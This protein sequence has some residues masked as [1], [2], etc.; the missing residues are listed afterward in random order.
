VP[1]NQAR[2]NA[3]KPPLAFLNPQIYPLLGTS[4]FRDIVRGINGAYDS[5]PGYDTVTGIGVPDAAQLVQKLTS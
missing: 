2:A 5:S 3:G 1:I 4:C